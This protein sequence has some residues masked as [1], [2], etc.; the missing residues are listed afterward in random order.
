MADEKFGILVER[1]VVG[2]GVENELRV[3]N[4]LLQDERIHRADDH[5]A[6]TVDDEC[7]LSECG[8]VSWVCWAMGMVS[9]CARKDSVSTVTS[10][11]VEDVPGD[12]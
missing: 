2:V 6:A 5:V 7:R 9:L 10:V 12:E 1:A 11:D 4:V 8:A 3:W